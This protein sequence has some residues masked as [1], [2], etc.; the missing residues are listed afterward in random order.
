MTY[1]DPEFTSLL[2]LFTYANT[3]SEGY[4]GLMIVIA[5]FIIVQVSMSYY[6]FRRALIASGFV[7]AFTTLILSTV[8]LVSPDAV[9]VLVVLFGLSLF[10]VKEEE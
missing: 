4:F 9:L 8:G 10:L 5:T 2:D 3:V 7:T 6:G 1:P